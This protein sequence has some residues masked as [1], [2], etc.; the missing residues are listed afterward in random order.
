MPVA[1][2]MLSCSLPPTEREGGRPHSGRGRRERDGRNEDAREGRQ[3]G[4][5]QMEKREGEEGGGRRE[6]W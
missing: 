5:E 4:R 2:G 1:L 3:R 6:P